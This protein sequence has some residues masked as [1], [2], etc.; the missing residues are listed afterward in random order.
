MEI[1]GRFDHFNFNV[2]DLEKSIRFYEKAL[3]LKEVRRKTASD[4]SFILVYMGDGETIGKNLTI[5]E[6]ESITF[7]CVSREIM[8]K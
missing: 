3:G 5:W 4:G 7:A 1:K 2:L 6:K 8:I